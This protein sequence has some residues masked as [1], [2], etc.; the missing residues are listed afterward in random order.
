MKTWK[1][2]PVIYVAGPYRSPTE[3]GVYQNIRSAEKVSLEIWKMGGAA[4]CPHKNTEMFGGAAEDSVWLEGDMAILSLCHAIYAMPTWK[5]STG[6]IAELKL[7]KNLD[8]PIFEC[9]EKLNSW[10]VERLDQ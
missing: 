3:W 10:I 9:L 4:I 2:I 1:K 6:A 7:A 5:Q 8:I